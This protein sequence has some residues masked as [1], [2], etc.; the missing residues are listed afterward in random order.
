MQAL[1]VVELLN[2]LRNGLHLMLE[3]SPD[4]LVLQRTEEASTGTLS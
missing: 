3:T 4:Q 2:V 1:A